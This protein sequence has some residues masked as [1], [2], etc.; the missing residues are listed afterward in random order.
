MKNKKLVTVI[1]CGYNASPFLRESIASVLTQTYDCFELFLIDDGSTDDTLLIMR[2]YSQYDSRV[3][4]F[5]HS[6]KGMAASL[7]SIVPLAKSEIIFRL[8]ADD[9]MYP[10]RLEFQLKF[11]EEN[12]ELGGLSCL[13]NYIDDKGRIIG[14]T[15]SDIKSIADCKKSLNNNE[16]VGFLHPGFVFR[17]DV[18]LKLD[19]YDGKF[20]PAEDIDL[21]NKFIENGFH[22]ITYP[23]I[24]VGYR[25]HSNSVITSKFL[26]SRKVFEWLRY[27][28][29]ARRM[30][31]IQPSR[32][33]FE[34]IQ[35]KKGLF[36]KINNV[37]KNH[38]KYYYRN[39][40]FEYAKKKYI[41]F[42]IKLGISLLLQPDLVIKKLLKQ[43]IV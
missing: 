1:I 25:I 37:R 19:G 39:A 16:I 36:F 10:T 2:E 17:K 3:T 8:D 32:E 6:N 33:E 5:T 38:S 30:N 40:G 24:L 12:P 27:C 42:F 31:Q 22:I 9:I 28:I 34:V 14:Q 13:G 41:S 20:W 21:C 43:K 4:V 7:N 26:E 23:Q 29:K 15:Y 18:F 11:L 35:T